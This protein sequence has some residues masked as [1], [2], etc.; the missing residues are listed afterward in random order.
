MGLE[1]A[2]GIRI[3]YD[4]VDYSMFSRV[5]GGQ[6]NGE[7][8]WSGNDFIRVKFREE[9][10][11]EFD[12][13]DDGTFD[14]QL[15]PHY[16]AMQVDSEFCGVKNDYDLYFC[17][18][19][20]VSSSTERHF[21]YTQLLNNLTDIFAC[22]ES[23]TS[24]SDTEQ[25]AMRS[26]AAMDWKTMGILPPSLLDDIATT[27]SL[28]WDDH[29]LDQIN[30]ARKVFQATHQTNGLRL[31]LFGTTNNDF[32]YIAIARSLYVLTEDSGAF[33]L[34]PQGEEFIAKPMSSMSTETNNSHYEEGIALLIKGAE[35]QAVAT[36]EEESAANYTE[37]LRRW[38]YRDIRGGASF[39]IL[40]SE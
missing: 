22:V 1:S 16:G 24:P 2:E 19:P 37:A 8:S 20:L 21:A 34:V 12:L 5:A 6:C 28:V 10:G 9:V 14:V 32:M 40:M 35:Q 7:D 31:E 23:T 33:L 39:V 18:T 30:G 38:N 13:D 3:P 15:N 25:Q 26:Y 29:G 11:F 4:L 36:Q 17:Y 27:V